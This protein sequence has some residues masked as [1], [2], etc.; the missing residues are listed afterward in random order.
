MGDSSIKIIGYWHSFSEPHFPDPAHFIDEPVDNEIKKLTL[1]YLRSGIKTNAIYLGSS[2]CRFRCGTPSTGSAEYTDGEY[3]WPEG[4]L[5]YVEHHN[6]RLPQIILDKIL[7]TPT[8]K[9]V[10]P[11]DIQLLNINYDWW[12]NQRG[13]NTTQ[14]SYRSLNPIGRLT[15]QQI[16]SSKTDVQEIVLKAFLFK[17]TGFSQKL[18]QV[19]SILTGNKVI[20]NGTFFGYEHFK[21]EAEEVGLFTEFEETM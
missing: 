5:H 2:W 21:K 17:S 18:R 16:E 15:I 6:I 9:I 4:L 20:L 7:S 1:Q 14:K 12:K 13:T 11:H 8:Q 3:V 19:R 10:V